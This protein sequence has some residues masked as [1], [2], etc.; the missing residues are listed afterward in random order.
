MVC[1]RKHGHNEGDDP[2][3]TQPKLYALIDNHPDPRQV[4]S[5][6][7]INASDVHADLAREMEKSFW[8]TLQERLDEVKQHPLPFYLSKAGIMVAEIA[9]NQHPK[10]LTNPLLLLLPGNSLIR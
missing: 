9:Q 6:K 2:K 10:I 7:L 5:Q 1:Y 8:T 3:Y 4:Y